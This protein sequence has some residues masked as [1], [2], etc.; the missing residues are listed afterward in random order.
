[1]KTQLTLTTLLT[2]FTLSTVLWGCT[3]ETADLADACEVRL[4]TP[5]PEMVFV[6]ESVSFTGTPLTEIRD[7]V[8]LVGGETH[9][10][11]DLTRL[12]CEACDT[13]RFDAPECSACGDCDECDDVCNSCT[14]SISF[15]ATNAA[16]GETYISIYNLY[17]AS[18]NVPLTILESDNSTTTTD[19]TSSGD[20]GTVTDTG[21]SNDT[22]TTG[23]T[24]ATG[25][26]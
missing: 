19:T 11:A 8:L 26:Q 16:L 4:D 5:T 12:D 22:G 7:T 10:I 3:S 25:T 23:D 17:G 1:M 18:N 6:G 14:E 2:C 13:C 20:T 21:A 24:G 9:E 15:T